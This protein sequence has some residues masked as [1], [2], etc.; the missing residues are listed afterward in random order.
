MWVELIGNPFPALRDVRP[1]FDAVRG[2]IDDR[3]FLD[4]A[5]GVN[6]LLFRGPER[7]PPPDAKGSGKGVSS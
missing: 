3:K 4:W 6:C 2:D 1:E 5:M 7:T